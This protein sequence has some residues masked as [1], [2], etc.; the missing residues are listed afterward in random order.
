LVW[1]FGLTGTAIL[2]WMAW[3]RSL[4]WVWWQYLIFALIALDVLGGVVA[5]SLNTC[6]RFYHS[7]V[8]PEE[9]GSAARSKNHVIFTA[10]HIHPVIA[11]LLFGSMNWG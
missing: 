8:K 7:P 2:G 9:T 10:Y 4:P 6:K 5:N 11:G 3:S 1:F